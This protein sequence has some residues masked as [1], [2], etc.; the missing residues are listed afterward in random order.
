MRVVR[1]VDEEG[2]TR[3][4]TDLDNHGTVE[5]V[6]G[7]LFGELIPSGERARTEP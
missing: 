7:D 2:R 1:F 5:V 6:A 4:G 3:L